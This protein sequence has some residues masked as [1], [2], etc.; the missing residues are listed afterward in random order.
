M[1]SRFKFKC[2]VSQVQSGILMFVMFVDNILR[3]YYNII[4][5]VRFKDYIINVQLHLGYRSLRPESYG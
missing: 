3:E 4:N 1:I 5:V 2:D